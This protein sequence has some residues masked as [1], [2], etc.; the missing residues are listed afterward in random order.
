MENEL[1][2]IEKANALDLFTTVKGLDPILQGIRR[3][4]D[5]FT[6]DTSTRKGRESIA[7]IAAKVARSKTYLDGVGKELVDR[8]KEQPKLVDA[9]RKR[10]RYTLDAWRD[11]VRK[12]LTEYEEGEK[13]RVNAIK[14]RIAYFHKAETI[15]YEN[16]QAIRGA[17]GQ[18][19]G[20]TVDES[21]QEFTDEAQRARGSALDTLDRLLK[22]SIRH[23][24]QQAELDRLRREKEELAQKEREERQAREVKEREERMIREAG[25]RAKREA[26]AKARKAVEDSMR[27]EVEA[28]MALE[29]AER[30][31][32]EDMEG[33]EREHKAELERIETAA[34]LEREH[35]AREERAKQEAQAEAE[36]DER[37]RQADKKHRTEVANEA[38]EALVA[39]ADVEQA[40]ARRIVNLIHKGKIPH[41]SI[42]F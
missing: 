15:E 23:E 39:H 30:K 26:E 4:I 38:A 25:E 16:S 36:R 21:Y 1:A 41:V 24:E 28:K 14:A 31:A 20:Q 17:I 3:E 27:R 11:E 10:I 5:S 13:A 8:L 19:T 33:R 32:K 35:I 37:A 12:P 6:P 34:R 40:A 9:E 2:V 7:S 18:V 42:K 22:A 29:S